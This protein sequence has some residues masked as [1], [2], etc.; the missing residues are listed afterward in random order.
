MRFVWHEVLSCEHEK[1]EVSYLYS[2]SVNS[3]TERDTENRD[4]WGFV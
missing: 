2:F 1:F 3:M 4:E